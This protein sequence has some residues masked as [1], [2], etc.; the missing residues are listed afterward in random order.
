MWDEDAADTLM[1]AFTGTLLTSMAV[2]ILSFLTSYLRYVQ[3]QKWMVC[4]FV[5]CWFQLRTSCL[6]W[7]VAR[8]DRRRG[9]KS[10]GVCNEKAGKDYPHRFIMAEDWN[11]TR[12]SKCFNTSSWTT[13]HGPWKIHRS[14]H[15]W[16]RSKRE[17]R[18]QILIQVLLHFCV[19]GKQLINLKA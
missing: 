6:D 18:N 14:Y 3:F 15:F 4:V 11:E 12:K 10:I 2:L 17:Y 19:F 7:G 16:W 1:N 13:G 5:S 9:A 8:W